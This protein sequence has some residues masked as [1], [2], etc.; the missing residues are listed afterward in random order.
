[1]IFNP[2]S[3]SRSE[4]ARL[5]KSQHAVSRVYSGIFPQVE[6]PL[7]CLLIIL[8][9]DGELMHLFFKQTNVHY[10]IRLLSQFVM[11]FTRQKLKLFVH[12]QYYHSLDDLFKRYPKNWM[13]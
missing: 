8:R 2:L 7:S 4:F 9:R 12:S 11:K 6:R 5:I 3:R 10:D 1:M 13:E